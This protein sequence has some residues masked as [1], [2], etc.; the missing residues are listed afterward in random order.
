MEKIFKQKQVF[1]QIPAN[2]NYANVFADK[3]KVREVDD[4]I[5][6]EEREDITPEEKSFFEEMAEQEKEEDFLTEEEKEYD[7]PPTERNKKPNKK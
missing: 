6:L 1:L 4:T 5:Y 3:F 2:E 7:I